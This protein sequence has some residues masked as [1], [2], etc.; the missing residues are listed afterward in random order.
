MLR[1]EWLSGSGSRRPPRLPPAGVIPSLAG[2]RRPSGSDQG[3]RRC[4]AKSSRSARAG[5]RVGFPRP[6]T[7]EQ[8]GA[9]AMPGGELARSSGGLATVPGLGVSVP[10]ARVIPQRPT[11]LCLGA[12]P[13]Q[14][15]RARRRLQPCGMARGSGLRP[16][17]R[18]K[19]GNTVSTKRHRR[20][21]APA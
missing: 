20:A 2:A 4:G 3:C 8:T 14:R 15:A 6:R 12:S 10:G 19:T 1:D 5:R 21:A 13:E 17:L 7:L 16:A 11:R 9:G 18:R